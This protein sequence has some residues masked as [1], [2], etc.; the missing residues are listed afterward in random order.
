MDAAGIRAARHISVAR[1]GKTVWDIATTLTA[2][3][4]TAPAR[5]RTVSDVVA[6]VC[7]IIGDIAHDYGEEGIDATITTGATNVR[8][9]LHVE[10]LCYGYADRGR[11]WPTRCAHTRRM[12]RCLQGP[13]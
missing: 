7:G 12:A 8:H 6:R 5:Y 13:A 9:H 4:F 3:A 11:C 10:P 2:C 1:G